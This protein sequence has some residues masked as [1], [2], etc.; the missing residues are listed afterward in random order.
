MDE[1]SDSTDRKPAD[2]VLFALGFAGF[3]FGTAG[4]IVSSKFL[5]VLGGGMLLLAVFSF[6][7]R[8]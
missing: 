7:L 6:R 5:T 8:E 3:I 4:V 2:Y 1:Y